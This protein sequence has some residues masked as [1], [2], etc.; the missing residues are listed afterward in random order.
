MLAVVAANKN[1]LVF[2]DCTK[3]EWHYLSLRKRK[4][5]K[6]IKNKEG[7][8]NAQSISTKY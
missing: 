3:Q 5:I 7:V 8:Q 2:Y 6:I 1:G 4:K